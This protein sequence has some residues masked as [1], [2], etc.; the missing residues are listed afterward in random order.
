MGVW[1]GLLH[2]RLAYSLILAYSPDTYLH[3]TYVYTQSLYIQTTYNVHTFVQEE[4]L[5]KMPP[6]R[7]TFSAGSVPEEFSSDTLKRRSKFSWVKSNFMRRKNEKKILSGS[8]TDL[9]SNRSS[10]SIFS[11]SSDA[12]NVQGPDPLRKSVSL[13]LLPTTTDSDESSLLEGNMD[14]EN[15]QG[16]LRLVSFLLKIRFHFPYL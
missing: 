1:L 8:Q 5:D 14:D 7:K 12:V 13:E 10:T 2:F 16:Y 11:S 4:S 6:R 9:H 3:T 15:F